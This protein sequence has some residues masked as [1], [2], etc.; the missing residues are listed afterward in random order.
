MLLFS[1]ASHLIWYSRVDIL[2][3]DRGFYSFTQSLHFFL[4]R[5]LD[6]ELAESSRIFSVTEV[7]VI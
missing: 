1:L 7:S 6:E 2:L 4:T 5:S 3:F